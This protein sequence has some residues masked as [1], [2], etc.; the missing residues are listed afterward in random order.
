M[1]LLGRA[2]IF[3][4]AVKLVDQKDSSVQPASRGVFQLHTIIPWMLSSAYIWELLNYWMWYLYSI[5]RMMNFDDHFLA[6]LAYT[7]T[8]ETKLN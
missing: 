4:Y 6:Q 3:F 1:L 8:S 2:H 5:F 7:S